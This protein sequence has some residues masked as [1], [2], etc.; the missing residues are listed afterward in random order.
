[1]S[2]M[3]STCLFNYMFRTIEAST[4]ERSCRP[5]RHESDLKTLH[6]PLVVDEGNAR[7]PFCGTRGFGSPTKL[8][9]LLDRLGD[10]FCCPVEKN[11][12][13]GGYPESFTNA[14]LVIKFQSTYQMV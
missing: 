10:G 14:F 13:T 7:N 6:H 3:E 11:K 8:K 2:L 5:E 9:C 1:M 12:V 4:L